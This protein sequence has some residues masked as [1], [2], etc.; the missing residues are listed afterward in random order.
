M[1]QLVNIFGFVGHMVFV[2]TM[3]HSCCSTKVASIHKWTDMVIK[4]YLQGRWWIEISPGNGV[5]W[6][7][8]YKVLHDPIHTSLFYLVTHYSPPYCLCPGHS[9]QLSISQKIQ[10][11]LHPRG[12]ALTVSSAWTTFLQV[13]I[14][15]TLW[16]NTD[17]RAKSSPQ[18]ALSDQSS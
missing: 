3:P 11:D 18:K 2:A 1:E 7:L 5:C 6:P 10:A 8:T 9:I 15:L 12:F 14:K 4:L 17:L 13:F 16:Q